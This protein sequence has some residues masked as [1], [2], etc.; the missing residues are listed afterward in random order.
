[1]RIGFYAPLKAPDHPVPSG[2]RQMARLLLAALHAA[3]H[4]VVLL[5]DFR[6]YLR[7]PNP[8]GLQRRAE[9]A[10]REVEALASRWTNRETPPDLLFAYH[11][12]YKAPDLVAHPLA[13]RFALPYVTAEASHAAKRADGRWREGH[14]AVERAVADAAVNFCFTA[15]DRGGLA[16]IAAASSLI[17]L[18][19]FIDAHGFAP[20]FPRAP[21][22]PVELVTVAMMR[23][24]DKAASYDFLAA[25]LARLAHLEW[26]ITLVG[27]GPA[28]P[29]VE[30]SFAGV[31]PGRVRWL[32]AQ[33]A[34]GVADLLRG[35]DLFVWPGFNEAFGLSYLEAQACGLPVLAVTGEGT[36]S[37]VQ[38]GRTGLLTVNSL[39]AYVEALERLIRDTLLRERLGAEAMRFVQTERTVSLASARLDAGLR[40]AVGQRIP[41]L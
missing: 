36:P 24:G 10:G 26:R 18:P 31:P 14:A 2:D 6:G 39:D 28:R 35:A 21:G 25:A 30:A 5:S 19:P 3:G 8:E 4:E 27:D 34:T 13:V 1:M 7:I 20:R 23:A 22:Q 9:A 32:G 29:S 33:S 15:N 37:V 12:Y 40:Q 41:S 17:D 11:L 38:H 16:D